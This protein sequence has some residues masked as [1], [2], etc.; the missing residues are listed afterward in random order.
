M[1][2]DFFFSMISKTP[3]DYKVKV[4]QSTENAGIYRVDQALKGLYTALNF[5]STSPDVEIDATNTD[6]V[7]IDFQS[8]RINGG[9]EDGIYYLL[10]LSA[11][12]P[13][14]SQTPA[15]Q[16]ATLTKTEKELV[17]N[18]PPKSLAY[19]PS[20]T[21]SIYY[22]NLNEAAK[23]TVALSGVGID[24]VAD[25]FNANAP[26]EYFNLQGQRVAN[27]AEGQLVI[28]RQGSKVKKVI[29]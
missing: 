11:N 17:F 9:T 10:T 13:D 21:S 2:G 16:R 6:N 7:V 25:E 29:F 19:W 26:V 1:S 5:T 8:T 23:L 4:Y 14:P 3:A 12:Y 27:P 28:V 20:N 15:A 24:K 18:F 22:A